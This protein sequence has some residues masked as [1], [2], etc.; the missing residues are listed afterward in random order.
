MLINLNENILK[1]KDL[2]A[3]GV[4][5]D[6]AKSCY[7]SENAV[8]ESG[9]HIEPMV[10]IKGEVFIGKNSIIG[11]GSVISSSKI[12]ANC[13][14]KTSYIEDCVLGDNIRVG[15]FAYLR[16]GAQI[17]NNCRIGDFVEIKASKLA[18][19]VKASHLAYIGDAEIGQ[20]TNVG[21][22][23][24]FANYNGKIKQKSL[25]GERVFIGCNTNLIAPVKIGDYSYIAAGST[26]TQDIPSNC[27]CIARVKQINKLNY[28]LKI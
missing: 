11:S 5:I 9:V 12:G 24:V 13:K 22:G 16:N 10:T 8:I 27:F 15:P 23:T 20:D 2:I 26:V 25:V 1:L 3:N 6:D 4:E 14:I 7:I 18:C 17:G 19:G 21:C 28:K